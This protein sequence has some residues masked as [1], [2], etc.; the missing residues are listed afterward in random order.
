MRPSVSCVF[1]TALVIALLVTGAGAA[2][3]LGFR[4]GAQVKTSNTSLTGDLPEEGS[5][6]GQRVFGAGLVAELNVTANVAIS[7]QPAYTRRDA[8][9]EFTDRRGEVTGSTDFDLSYVS[10]PLV[11]RVTAD[12]TGVRGFVTA[13][14][15]LGILVDATADAGSGAQDISNGLDPTTIGALFG[16]GVMVPLRRN[17]VAFEL[18]YVQGLDDIVDRAGGIDTDLISRSV[19]YRG[20][21]VLIGFLITLG[22]K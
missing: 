4:L 2:E 19:K 22:G 5:W 14:L 9:Q 20:F 7:F 10:L 15:D 12:S 17:Y 6:K 8:V 11:V 16:A 3:A 21:D 18:R 1:Q 13:G